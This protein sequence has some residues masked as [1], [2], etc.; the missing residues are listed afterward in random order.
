VRQ[1]P[2][3]PALWQALADV[4]LEA[5][6]PDLAAAAADEAVRLR[7]EL[8][9]PRLTAARAR[10]AQ[11]RPTDAAG[12][13]AAARP[14]LVR[15]PGGA[16]LYVRA[17]GE[18]GAVPLAD[19]FLA[20]ADAADNPAGVLA[21]GAAE[22]VRAGRTDAALR[23]AERAVRHDP[24][25]RAAR[26]VTADALRARAEASAPAWDAGRVAAAVRAY[27]WLARR[28]PADLAA[29]N[30]LA[31]LQLK[32]LGDAAAAAKSAAPLLAREADLPPEMA[33]TLGAVLLASG[34]A[35]A[36]VRV[37]ERAADNRA[38]RPGLLTHLALTYHAVGRPADAEAALRKASELPKTEREAA[39]WT[40]AWRQ[41]Q[42]PGLPGRP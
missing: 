36:A 42:A 32:G 2:E 17:L 25:S 20:E 15:D 11:D 5:G 29:A 3:E 9:P 14:A 38:A 19:D 37:L 6:R 31:W 28:D 16:A 13:L 34:R 12:V 35:P 41:I 24:E 7:P 1:R 18:A 23:W 10:L 26:Q 39:E 22:L 4:A 21:A 33:A 40:A 8:Y 27:E 30:N